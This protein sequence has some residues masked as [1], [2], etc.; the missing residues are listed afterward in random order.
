MYV[1]RRV[2]SVLPREA[3]RAATIVADIARAYEES[4]QRSDVRV[5]FNG[6]TLPGEK[7]RVYM[8]WL[9][10][11]IESPYRAGNE[12]P[13]DARDLSAELRELSTDSW[14]EFNELF[15]PDKAQILQV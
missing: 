12:I 1:I 4:G 10:D 9:A 5:Y 7:D 11:T 13:Q 14:I 15:T 6:G 2:W 3:R 8:E